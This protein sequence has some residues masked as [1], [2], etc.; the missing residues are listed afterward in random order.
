[1]AKGAKGHHE[2][3]EGFLAPTDADI[4]AAATAAPEIEVARGHGRRFGR[5]FMLLTPVALVSALFAVWATAGSSS[6]AAG[7]KGWLQGSLQGLWLFRHDGPG[8]HPEAIADCVFDAQFAT[9]NMMAFGL[10]IAGV[11]NSCPAAQAAND[12]AKEAWLNGAKKAHEARVTAVFGAKDEPEPPKKGVHGIA[13]AA[14]EKIQKVLAEIK[15]AKMSAEEKR[16]AKHE[17]KMEKRQAKFDAMLES[18]EQSAKSFEAAKELAKIGEADQRI[19]AADVSSVLARMGYVSSNL[20]ALSSECRMV[21]DQ[22]AF[23]AADITRILAGVT[24]AAASGAEIAASCTEYAD[25]IPLD[26]SEYEF[27]RRLS[28]VGDMFDH[29]QGVHQDMVSRKTARNVELTACVTV[30]WF[31]ATFFARFL[32]M[33]PAIHHCSGKGKGATHCAAAIVDIISSLA[34]TASSISYAVTLCPIKG[35]QQNAFCAAGI[36]KLV[37]AIADAT[38]GLTVVAQTCSNTNGTDLTR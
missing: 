8:G 20:A 25:Y 36:T 26:E 12:K 16:K 27:A 11:A 9:E 15:E 1:M 6:H 7:A 29:M 28:P 17:K 32:D 4:P 33:N 22:K 19:C 2:E 24:M 34:W 14:V 23:C 31:A 10:S 21:F 18:T 13:S 3:A 30:S 35:E 37:A 5:R 38:A